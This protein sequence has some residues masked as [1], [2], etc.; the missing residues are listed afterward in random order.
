MNEL[1]DRYVM[2][3]AANL[4]KRD[5]ADVPAELRDI[6]YSKAEAREA[7]LGRP[8]TRREVEDML[9]AYG[10]PLI[11]AGSYGRYHALIGPSVY[12]FYL[13]TLKLVGGI[14]LAIYVVQLAIVKVAGAPHVRPDPDIVGALFT[15][16]GVI[17]LV[18]ALIE[19]FGKP[20]KLATTWRV[21]QLPKLGAP[22][23]RRPFEILFE[24]AL[25]GAAI[26]WWVG[27]L[28]IPTPAPGF[29]SV[30]LAP[31][32]QSLHWP[33]LGYLMLQLAV[34][35][36]ELL[37]PGMARLHAAIR[38]GYHLLGLVLA[39]VIYQAGHW[40]DVT[41]T[42]ADRA[43]LAQRLNEGFNSGFKIGLIVSVFLFLFEVGR[44]GLRL[45]RYQ[46]LARAQ[47]A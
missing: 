13:F 18:F 30:H 6:L 8:L 21:S 34:D 23:G 27:L 7:E 2:A 39:A 42:L 19:R 10:H 28:P 14:M 1:I 41:V 47:A 12:P 17:T 15:V 37:A 20:E 31:V 45:I 9:R 44:A 33:I 29:I 22:S 32:W 40:L 43:D 35:L 5:R 4:P 26:A 3:V 11:V 25:V 46:R 36:F 38:L 16:G 24:M